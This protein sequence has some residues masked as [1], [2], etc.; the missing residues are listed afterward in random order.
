[1]R[2][3]KPKIKNLGP[4]HKMPAEELLI[5]FSH[6]SFPTDAD[7]NEDTESAFGYPASGE[8]ELYETGYL[9]KIFFRC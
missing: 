9:A 7:R 2:M 6:P 8:T 3:N 1:M 5:S 4:S